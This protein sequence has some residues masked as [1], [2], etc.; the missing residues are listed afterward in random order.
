MS[1][2]TTL[3]VTEAADALGIT[4]RQIRHLVSTRAVT[5]VKV[6]RLVRFRPADLEAYLEANTRRAVGL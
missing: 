6:G 3:G 4:E 5:Y 1:T 2:L